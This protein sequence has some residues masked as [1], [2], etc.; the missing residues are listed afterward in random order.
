[1][2]L[3]IKEGEGRHLDKIGDITGARC[4]YSKPSSETR[5]SATLSIW[6]RP[7]P[8]PGVLTPTKPGLILSAWERRGL[9]ATSNI[10]NDSTLRPSEDSNLPDSSRHAT[11]HRCRHSSETPSG[12]ARSSAP[13][14]DPAIVQ[15]HRLAR[16]EE[17]GTIVSR[18]LLARYF[19][20]IHPS[21]GR[22]KGAT[23]GIAPKLRTLQV[24]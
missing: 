10:F 5:L 2:I 7:R 19:G 1:M 22:D 17:D 13:S 16:P 9:R 8:G 3:S 4:G 24:L 23:S 15:R 14:T 21:E 20:Q 18:H 6:V 11:P 12:K